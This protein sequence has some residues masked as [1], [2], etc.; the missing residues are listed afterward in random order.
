MCATIA[1][2]DR[3][4]CDDFMVVRHRTQHRVCSLRGRAPRRGLDNWD[5]ADLVGS[6]R[7]CNLRSESA[8]IETAPQRNI[9][10]TLSWSLLTYFKRRER[11]ELLFKSGASRISWRRSTRENPSSFQLEYF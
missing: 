10:M 5:G 2:E 4:D 1:H 9:R 8:P 6:E 11:P 3:S 7:R